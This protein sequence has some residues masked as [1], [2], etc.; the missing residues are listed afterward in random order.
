MVSLLVSLTAKG[1]R[2]YEQLWRESENFRTALAGLLE[3][4]DVKS[5]IDQ[6]RRIAA[7]RKESSAGAAPRTLAARRPARS[8]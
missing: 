4:G 2:A 3:P 7:M 6:L 1:R 8:R 5:L